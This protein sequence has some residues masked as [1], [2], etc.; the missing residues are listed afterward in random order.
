[1]L[2]CLGPLTL[3]YR[4]IHFLFPLGPLASRQG[5]FAFLKAQVLDLNPLGFGGP[6]VI[7]TGL[8]PGARETRQTDI[9]VRISA[10][11]L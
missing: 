1:M 10:A 5:V 3:H 8:F 6:T 4:A 2:C 11:K 9:I 7:V